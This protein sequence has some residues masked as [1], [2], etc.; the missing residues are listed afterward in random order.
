MATRPRREK[1]DNG[2]LSRAGAIGAM[3]NSAGL[4]EAEEGLQARSLATEVERSA[5]DPVVC[6]GG[7]VA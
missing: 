3:K 7:Y 1:G 5:C 4:L 6:V 2:R